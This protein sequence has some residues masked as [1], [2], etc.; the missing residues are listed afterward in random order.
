MKPIRVAIV[1]CGRIS[2]LHQLG[3]R[4]RDDARIVAVCDTQQANAEAKAKAW[5]VDKVYTDYEQVLEDREVDVVELLTPHHLHCPMTVAACRA[6]KHVSVQKPM[7]LSA[8]E[9]DQMIEAARA[10]GVML[11]VYETFVYYAPAVRAREMIDA[12]EIGEIRAVRM[13]INTGTNDTGWEVPLSAWVWRFDERLCGGGTAGLRSRL[14]PVLRGLFSRRAR[15]EGLRLDRPD[16][17][18]RTGGRAAIDAP[19]AIMFKYRADRCYGF[20]DVEHTPSMRIHSQY[21]T[22]DD[23]IEVIGEKGI[24]FINRYTTRTVDLP[25]LMLFK[26]GKTTTIPVDGVEWHDSFIATTHDLIDK[27]KDGGKPR[28]DGPTGKAVLQFALAALQS[29]ERGARSGRTRWRSSSRA[30]R[31]AP[32]DR[33]SRPTFDGRRARS[34]SLRSNAGRTLSRRHAIA[35]ALHLWHRQ[36]PLPPKSVTERIGYHNRVEHLV[37]SHFKRFSVDRR[38]HG[39]IGDDT[40]IVH[41]VLYIQIPKGCRQAHCRTERKDFLEHVGRSVFQNQLTYD[42]ESHSLAVQCPGCL[43]KRGQ[44]ITYGVCRCGA[45]VLKAQSAQE[46]V[47]F[48]NVLKRFDHHMFFRSGLCRKP[49]LQK[50]LIALLRDNASQDRASEATIEGIDEIGAVGGTVCPGFEQRRKRITHPSH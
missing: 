14:P 18:R 48:N 24:I 50:G 44:P 9:A 30:P 41:C 13:H 1:G 17:G 16:A 49:P 26:D 36:L 19:A 42:A 29:A 7:A 25:P 47:G 46:D 33:P 23:R 20:L 12:G 22:G 34:G 45:I 15:G 6:G 32:L 2:D 4:G 10:A 27:M 5:G 40:N 3:Y 35:P 31:A 38:M 8:A 28:L 43:A 21:Y 11:R 39:G 37:G